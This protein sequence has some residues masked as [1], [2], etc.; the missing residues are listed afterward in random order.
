VAAQ[1]HYADHHRQPK[2]RAAMGHHFA[3]IK[4]IFA[5]PGSSLENGRFDRRRLFPSRS[6]RLSRMGAY[7]TLTA[8]PGRAID[9]KC[10]NRAAMSVRRRFRGWH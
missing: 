9:T 2:G 1:T 10:R 7:A 8:P 4:K 5:S 6:G 3:K